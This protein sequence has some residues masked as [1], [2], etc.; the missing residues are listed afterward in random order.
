LPIRSFSASVASSEA[1]T[2][3]AVF[4]TPAVSQVGDEPGAGFS[5]TRHAKQGPSPGSTVITIP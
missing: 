5:P 1:T 2:A 3:T 4:S